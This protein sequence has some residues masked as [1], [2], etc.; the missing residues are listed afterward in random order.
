MVKLPAPEHPCSWES[1]LGFPGL[2]WA[3]S[4]KTTD[5]YVESSEG[6]YVGLARVRRE[7]NANKY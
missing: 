3:V 2:R 1:E 7:E 6:V 4:Q 5:L